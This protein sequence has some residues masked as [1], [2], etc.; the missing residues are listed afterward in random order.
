MRD[1]ASG[2]AARTGSGDSGTSAPWRRTLID[3][4]MLRFKGLNSHQ[5]LYRWG[6]T[7]PFPCL[8]YPCLF[9][10]TRRIIHCAALREFTTLQI[11]FLAY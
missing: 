11:L 1:V 5:R 7:Q 4:T 9:S 8:C 6:H 3:G 10:S 2:K